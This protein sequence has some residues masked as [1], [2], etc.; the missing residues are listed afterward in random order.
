VAADAAR[1][2]QEQP[3]PAAGLLREDLRVGLPPGG[4]VRGQRIEG[5]L[6]AHQQALV[7]GQRLAQVGEEDVDRLLLGLAHG[8]PGRRVGI[9]RVVR[10][11]GALRQGAG[12]GQRPEDRLV[13]RRQLG[14][15]ADDVHQLDPAGA[16]LPGVL[17]GREGLGP[18]RVL[19]AVPVEPALV[20]DVE[21]VRG[22]AAGG[23]QG[24][25]EP[26][27]VGETQV[28]VVAAGAGDGA[29]GGE[30]SAEE[31]RLAQSGGPGVVGVGVGGVGGGRGHRRQP[32]D[33]LHLLGGEDHR[34]H[35]ARR[36]QQVHQGDHQGRSFCTPARAA[37]PSPKLG[38]TPNSG[39]S[40]SPACQPSATS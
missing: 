27:A 8:L 38:T 32:A 4:Q 22:V 9:G 13:A 14:V 28:G 18:D 5:R 7:G 26:A 21:E 24:L 36:Q 25:G 12:V 10:R 35:A 29:V 17:Q 20:G 15:A 31:Q 34:L 37:M 11:A 39:L 23:A 33:R 6:G 40:W 3:Q 16:V 2:P 1:R 19:A 30:R